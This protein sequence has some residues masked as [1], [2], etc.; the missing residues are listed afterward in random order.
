MVL[1]IEVGSFSVE[2]PFPVVDVGENPG[3]KVLVE[4][5]GFPSTKYTTWETVEITSQ[6]YSRTNRSVSV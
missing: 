2:V 3:A 5:V 4:T 6:E 1:E